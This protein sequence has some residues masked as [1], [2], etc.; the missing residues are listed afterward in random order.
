MKALTV[1]ELYS[2]LRCERI[3]GNGEKKIL[4]TTDDEGN[5]CHELFFG[6]SPI[7]GFDYMYMPFGVTRENINEYVLLG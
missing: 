3:K 4:L 6:I 1:D 5:G 2:I 7:D